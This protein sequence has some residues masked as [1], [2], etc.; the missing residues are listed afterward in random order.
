MNLFG[1]KSLDGQCRFADWDVQI[2]AAGE[3]GWDSKRPHNHHQG[4]RH[5]LAL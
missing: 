3:T 2:L 1:N 4:L 5:R